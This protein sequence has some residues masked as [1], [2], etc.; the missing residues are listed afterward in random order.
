MREASPQ[1]GLSSG[2]RVEVTGPKG[3]RLMEVVVDQRLGYGFA[4]NA[5]DLTALTDQVS[6]RAVWMRMADDT[7]TS[8]TVAA[9]TSLAKRANAVVAG[10]GPQRVQLASGLAIAT[11]IIA[12][13]LAMSVLIALVGIGNTLALSVH[14]RSRE[15][16]LLRALG[17]TRGQIRAMLALEGGLLAAVG[18][19]LGLAM[20]VVYGVAGA[21]G[22]LSGTNL[23]LVTVAPVGTLALI[24]IAGLAAG[25]LASALPG[26]R[27]AMT[28]PAGALAVD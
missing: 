28:A 1:D 8:A 3:S 24:G 21:R 10:S 26:R 18:T 12:G 15:S 23:P 4:V 16:A 5:A 13:L 19:L 17:V 11:Y 20:G 22:V 14:E 25:V 2:A 9:V 7:D 6:T 27:A